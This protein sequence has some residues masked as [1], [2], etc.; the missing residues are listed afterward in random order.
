[1]SAAD[2]VARTA[3]PEAPR[4][5]DDWD[6]HWDSFGSA[7]EGGP[8]N[9]YRRRLIVS[10]LGQLPATATLLDIGCGQGELAIFLRETYPDLAVW[11]VDVSA[12]GVELGRAHA[13]ARGTEV[14][15]VQRDLLQPVVLAAG[16]PAAGYAVCSEVLEHVDEPVRLLRNAR[17]LLAPGCRLVVTVPGGPRSAFDRHLGHRRHFTAAALRETLSDAGYQVERVFRAGFPFFNLYKLAVIGR[18]RRLIADVEDRK[19]DAKPSK[20]EAL[21]TSIF[22]HGFRHNRDDFAVG[23]QMAAVALVPPAEPA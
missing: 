15:F 4:P 12:A 16:Q 14:T 5:D 11:G 19:P 3:G 9:I 13:A 1:M 22:D 7:A 2:R 8:A 10:L 6:Q 17:T 23:W 20:L 18:G 21:A